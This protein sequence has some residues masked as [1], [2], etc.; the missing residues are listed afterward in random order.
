MHMSG[1]L[2][3]TAGSVVVGLPDS[4]VHG[5]SNTDCGSY[6]SYGGGGPFDSSHFIS[7]S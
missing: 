7:Y 4:I 6:A 1:L 5:F 2:L 3:G